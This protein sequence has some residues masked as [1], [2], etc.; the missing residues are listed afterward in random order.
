MAAPSYTTD[1]TTM[2]D[3]E[4]ATGW[5]EPS[6][7]SGWA[8]GRGVDAD[9]D[10]FIQNSS[11]IS[12][13]VKTGISGIIYNNGS[14]IT[15]NTDD[16]V[17]VWCKYD[18]TPTLL[19]EAAGGLRTIQGSSD[20]AFYGFKQLG[21]DSYAYGGWRNLATG[22][23]ADS[24]VTEDYTVGSPSTTKQ[25]HGFAIA[26]NGNVPSKGNPD[27][28]DAIRYGRC[29]LRCNG[30]ETA[31][32]ANAAGAAAVNDLNVTT[33]NRWGLFQAIDG[34]YLWKGLWTLGYSSAVDWR[35]S[36]VNITIDNTKHTT[37]NFNKI[38]IDQAGSR[39]DWTS[40]AF[41]SLGT[42]SPGRFEM[43]AAADVNLLTCSFSDMDTFIFQS[44]GSALAC[45]WVRCNTIT[46]AGADLTGSE[47]L[48]PV[49]AANTSAVVWDVAT[50]PDGLLDDM[51]FSKGT[52][53]HHAIE[54]G[55]T[56]PSGANYTL[57]GCDFGTGFSGT[58][59]GTTGDE[60]FHF[61]DTTG[62]ITLNLVSCTGNAGYRTEG[63]AVTIITDPVTT[64]I[65]VTDTA[66]PPVAISG[67]RV[68][69]ETSNGTGP[70]PFAESVGITQ[71]GG[72][73]TVAHTGHG[74]STDHYVVIRGAVPNEYNKVAQI[75][76]VDD[77]EYTYSVDSGASSPATGSPVSSAVIISALSTGAG[78]VSDTRTFSSNQPFKGWA[79]KS[80]GSPYYQNGAITGTISST[81][82]FTASIALLSDE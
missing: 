2:S 56:I 73:A 61:K 29:E 12:Q 43:L 50:D 41:V 32:Y 66:S 15:L 58:E 8:D 17:L 57:R 44:T 74:L 75:T 24:E 54:F 20:A 30:G 23:R 7:G 13:Q 47:V 39:V 63:V 31:D 51:T 42:K 67:A 27:K 1:L 52:A 35:D 80:S 68:F 33:F 21:S 72:T 10:D 71:S 81:D 62:T 82:G 28:C 6:I 46:A 79:R 59:G 69:I 19:S 25:Y 26:D 5:S 11:C 53:A 40:Y 78:L 34:G 77:D 45:S 64:A 9:G 49:V 48:L 14:G 4:S 65:T 38:E 55:T 3:A 22:D 16:A 36:D 60:T 18:A 37:K 76:R 70:L